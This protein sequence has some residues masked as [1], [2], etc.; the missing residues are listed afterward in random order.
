MTATPKAEVPTHRVLPYSALVGQHRICTAL[1]LAYVNPAIGGVLVVGQ[2][3]TAKST[4]VR[5]FA[6]MASERLPVTLPLG[7]T[8]DRVVGGWNVKSLLKGDAEEMRG[9]LEEAADSAGKLLY[10]D[11]VNLLDDHLVDLLLDVAASGILHTQREGI[12][13]V[14]TDVDFTLVG[15]MN[16][17]EGGLRPQLLDRFGLVAMA[18]PQSSDKERAEIIRAVMAFEEARQDPHSSYW[19]TAKHDEKDLRELLNA[20]RAALP[21]VGYRDVVEPCARL[22]ARFEV[23][24]H[25]GPVALINAGAAMAALRE[26]DTVLPAHLRKVARLAL[27]HRRAKNQSDTIPAWTPED[28]QIVAEIL[29]D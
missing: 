10:V 24:G 4:A 9:L 12:T 29:A 7:A 6:M 14:R 11:E 5:S 19:E 26:E 18:E 17:D 23:V 13:A 8:E 25:R 28:D 3:G 15:T 1:E 16:P 21:D 22:A 20:A 2:R 27:V